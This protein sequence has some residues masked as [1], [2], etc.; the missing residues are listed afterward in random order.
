MT[1][2]YYNELSKNT[3]HIIPDKVQQR[4]ISLLEVKLSLYT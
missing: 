3:Y 4:Y 1:C 2:F